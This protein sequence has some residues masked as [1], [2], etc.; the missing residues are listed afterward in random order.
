MEYEKGAVEYR[1]YKR[2]RDEGP[3]Q[4]CVYFNPQR[5]GEEYPDGSCD[6]VQGRIKSNYTCDLFERGM[7]N[8]S[9]EEDVLEESLP[10]SYSEGPREYMRRMSMRYQ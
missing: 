4:Y 3:C 9:P 7:G 8:G 5:T 2:S 10:M 1:P 6:L